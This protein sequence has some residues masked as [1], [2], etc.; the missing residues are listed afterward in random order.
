MRSIFKLIEQSPIANLNKATPGIYSYAAFFNNPR[1]VQH[2]NSEFA[3]DNNKEDI[4]LQSTRSA[5]SIEPSNFQSNLNDYEFNRTDFD[6]IKSDHIHICSLSEN[7]F[8][9]GVVDLLN[10]NECVSVIV[11]DEEML[12]GDDI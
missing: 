10:M 9:D 4:D 2:L 6:F 5:L 12:F 1:A 8:L 11:D 3:E 7:E